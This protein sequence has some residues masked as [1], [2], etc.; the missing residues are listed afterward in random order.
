MRTLYRVK[1]DTES[2][3]NIDFHLK[4]RKTIESD[5][6]QN[7]IILKNNHS[8]PI[9]SADGCPLILLSRMLSDDVTFYILL[10]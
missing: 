1:F 4:P 6:S 2:D 10:S 9:S 3:G 7:I 8:W 5:L